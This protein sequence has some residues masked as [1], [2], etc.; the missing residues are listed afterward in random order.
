MSIGK[1]DCFSWDSVHVTGNTPLREEI[2]RGAEWVSGHLAR[3]LALLALLF[4]C[5]RVLIASN[6]NVET[7]KSLVQDLDVTTLV[8]ATLL[9]FTG[10]V[11]LWT[12]IVRILSTKGRDLISVTEYIATFGITALLLC[13][14]MPLGQLVANGVALLLFAIMVGVGSCAAKL[15]RKFERATTVIDV[16]GA[17]LF[18][19]ILVGTVVAPFIFAGRW[20]PKECITIVGQRSEAGYVLSSDESWTKF[21]D[22]DRNIHIVDSKSVLRRDLIEETPVW[23]HQSIWLRWIEPSWTI[24]MPN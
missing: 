1:A 21:M 16:L 14:T 8:L 12:L 19:L 15:P 2:E 9:P 11:V 4:A 18:G 10:T 23:Y 22:D 5:A 13:F 17:A 3:V 7:L 20:L 6:G 24:R